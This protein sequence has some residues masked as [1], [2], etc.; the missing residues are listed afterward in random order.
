MEG[1]TVMTNKPYHLADYGGKRVRLTKASLG[2]FCYDALTTGVE[3]YQLWQINTMR[4]SAV[5]PAI[6][7][8]DEQIE[9]LRTL[10]Y[11]FVETHQQFI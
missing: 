2:Q 9:K 8:T 1:R 11:H 3:I 5:Y 6:K 10:G 7:A 4:G